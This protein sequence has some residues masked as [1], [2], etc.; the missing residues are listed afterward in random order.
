MKILTK[1]DRDYI[2]FM[3]KYN[4]PSNL[5]IGLAY[6]LFNIQYENV[7]FVLLGYTIGLLSIMA[8]I[9]I[10]EMLF[11]KVSVETKREDNLA[12]YIILAVNIAIITAFM[13]IGINLAIR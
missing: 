6:L 5:F 13:I 11:K 1:A 8:S 2:K 9:G 12:S 10:I 4:L 3:F 7:Y